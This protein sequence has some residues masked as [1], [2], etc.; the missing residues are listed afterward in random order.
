MQWSASMHRLDCDG[1]NDTDWFDCIDFIKFG[2][3]VIGTE[4]IRDGRVESSHEQRQLS[5][6]LTT[7][8]ALNRLPKNHVL[9]FG[10]LLSWSKEFL[11]R[12]H[13]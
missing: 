9:T 11:I 12:R 6:N 13:V 3:V 2:D 8:E 7:S 10:Y 1:H 5:P 4:S